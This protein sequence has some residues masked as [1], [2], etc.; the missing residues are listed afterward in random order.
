MRKQ[1]LGLDLG[2]NSIGWALLAVD[3]NQPVSIVDLGCRIFTRAVEEKTPI[4]K[5]AARRNSRL[6]R[7]V[8]QRRSARKKRMQNYL[9]K[10][11]FLPETLRNNLSPE[12]I[13]NEIGDPYRL[14]AIALDAKLK[15][16]ELGRVL[17][18]LTQRRGFLSNRKTIL[19]D[20]IDD[21]D[22]LQVIE[23][24]ENADDVSPEVAKEE[25]AF[26][27][28][29]KLLKDKIDKAGA[30]TLGEYL[31][32][33]HDG[34]C[35][36]NRLRWGGHLRTDRQMYREEL[37][38]ICEQQAKHHPAL[39]EQVQQELEK[40]IFFQ[41]PLKFKKDSIGKCSLET[42]KPRAAIAKLESQ[43]FRYLQDINNLEFFDYHSESWTA[44]SKEQKTILIDLFEKNA[45]LTFPKIRK[46]LKLT[47]C[48]F[49]L[50]RGDKK[51]K[52]NITA[53]KIRKFIDDWDR[54]PES[55][56]FALVED[57]VTIKKKSVLKNRLI[58]H[59][60]FPVKTA[61][62]LC[63]LELE[64][65]HTSLSLKAIKK[66]LPY[67]RNGEI[68][69]DARIHAGY[70]Y[71][72]KEITPQDR[73]KPPPEIPNP[74]V[75][76]GLHELR[77]LI[78]AIIAKYGKPDAIRL[79]MAR[80]LEMNTKRYQESLKRQKANLKANDEAEEKYREMLKK[81]PH[82]RLSEYMSRNDKLKYR[83]WIDQDMRCAYSGRSINMSTLFSAEVDIDHIL[84][85]SLTIDD[86]YMNKV[87]CYV[88]EN[89]FKGQKT[90][91]DAYGESENWLQIH[92]RI[93]RWPK[94]LSAKRDKFYKK[95]DEIRSDEFINSQLNDTRYICRVANNYLKDLGVDI[96]VS[97]GI[98]TSWL[99][100]M[101]N[102]NTLLGES[103]NKNRKDYRHHAI[104]AAVVACID[105]SFY[106]T[107]I[108][109]AKKLEQERGEF[110][111][112]QLHLDPP[113][114]G[115]RADLQEKLQSI[116]IAHS[117]QKKL[118][119]ALHEDTGAG[120]IEGLGTIYRKNLDAN[121]TV[122]QIQSIVDDEVKSIITD[123]LA[124]HDN[125][126]KK[127]FAENVTVLHRDGITPIKR[128][129]VIQ[130]GTYTTK[131]KL[132]RTKFGVRNKE[133]N[134]F[135]WM[136]FGNL[137]HIEII[138]NKK[139]NEHYGI[140]VTNFEANQRA[141]GISCTKQPVVKKDHDQDEFI[142]ALHINDMVSLKV[143][144]TDK[145]FRV[146]GLGQLDQNRQPRP[147]LLP[148]NI[149]EGKEEQLSDSIKN[150]IGK[151]ELK[152][153]KVNAIGHQINDKNS[154]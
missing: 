127:A 120:F 81:S 147:V 47:K 51:L 79:E 10:L 53:C 60:N 72:L 112:N 15:P 135:K 49:N 12:I 104:D 13:L 111:V 43:Q 136:T 116:I 91:I 100:H 108:K 98:T 118:T 28:D 75:Q 150:L 4:P 80:D 123:H 18:H 40:I 103:D 154:R 144:G 6:T 41:R 94:K 71:D 46:A 24:M 97:K 151:Y 50:E 152:L 131:N 11:G 27:N 95:T 143:N 74:I 126:P 88:E 70:D 78:N 36:R 29:I 89:R 139:L 109:T 82:L 93:Q 113:W 1:I 65:G 107:L 2:T 134:I 153:L 92:Q 130:S 3:D 67:L 14:R 16:H 7:R 142:L 128:V 56:Q 146:K 30:R 145:I 22:V 42:D 84:P 106:Q 101:W 32:I 133:G 34:P 125:N 35:R 58:S 17:L 85:Y 33:C 137:H 140:F 21:P 73:L 117:P 129:R 96:S 121:F 61:V 99:R 119:G 44:L 86:S 124:S 110:K 64:P 76:K 148:H 141:K 9:I 31:A 37:A 23:E 132:E 55:R 122:K 39:T 68:Y 62:D 66:L 63:M 138:K 8:L 69:S 5:N 90:P 115:L 114:L 19:G 52:G 38:L 149:S 26:K 105:R 77:R 57:L 102:L 87:V 25:T 59:W 20:M 48:E 45:F 54:Y 83:L